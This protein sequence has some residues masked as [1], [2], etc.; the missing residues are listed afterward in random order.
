MEDSLNLMRTTLDHV[1]STMGGVSVCSWHKAIT[2]TGWF[3][4]NAESEANHNISKIGQK[5][6]TLG[7]A[8][9]HAIKMRI[10]SAHSFLS[11]DKIEVW[12]TIFSLNC[13]CLGKL[14]W[15]TFVHTNYRGLWLIVWLLAIVHKFAIDYVDCKLI[16]RITSNC[17]DYKWLCRITS[18]SVQLQSLIILIAD[19][20]WFLGL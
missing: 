2:L 9:S 7:I 1:G 17:V 16:C 19:F 20:Q 3:R 8:T 18:N 12:I 5:L 11:I 6:Q 13:N 15:I 14:Q 4:A 10:A